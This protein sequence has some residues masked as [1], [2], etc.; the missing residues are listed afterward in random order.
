VNDFCG[1]WYQ[2][3]RSTVP[4]Y[5]CTKVL[6]LRIP[7]EGKRVSASPF[8]GISHSEQGGAVHAAPSALRIIS[9]LA[10]NSLA[11]SNRV[12]YCILHEMSD[13]PYRA[14]LLLPR[15][16]WKCEHGTQGRIVTRERK[17]RRKAEGQQEQT[18]IQNRKQ[19]K[20]LRCSTNA[21]KFTGT[22]SGGQ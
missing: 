4:A 5:L 9:Q 6:H 16:P 14:C 8:D 7:P 21:A 19:R 1:P 11:I 18:K 13:S 3:L 20:A 2:Y 17:A 12:R 15:V 10:K 22:T